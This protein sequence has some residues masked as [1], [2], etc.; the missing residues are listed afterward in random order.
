MSLVTPSLVVTT[1]EFPGYRIVKAI[2]VAEGVA[3]AM[4]TGISP[5]SGRASSP[6]PSVKPSSI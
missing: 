2:G 5:S 6:R 1:D 3:V 4:F